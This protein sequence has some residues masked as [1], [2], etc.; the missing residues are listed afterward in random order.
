MNLRA[1]I[2]RRF[3]R[4]RWRH[5]RRRIWGQRLPMEKIVGRGKSAI[6]FAR[7]SRADCD[8]FLVFN[9]T[10]ANALA[11]GANLPAF[12]QRDLPREFA[13]SERRMWR[14]GVFYRGSKLLLVGGNDGKIDIAQ[15]EG[16]WPK[17]A[18]CIR[19]GRAQSVLRNRP[20]WEPFTRAIKSRR[21]AKLARRPR[22]VVAHGWRAFRQCDRLARLHAEG[23][24][25]EAGVDVLC[26]GGTKNGLGAGELVV[27]FNKELAYQFDY[28]AKQ[29]GQLGSKMRFLAAPWMGVIE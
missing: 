26:L 19:I 14:A 15:A 4:K 20:S 21:F 16:S 9:G 6:A 1:T 11:L 5:W 25:L 10:A 13:Y 12:S 18:N 22:P 29:G 8:V 2:R 28:R 3:V 17:Q 24:Y 27:F 23:N 7:S